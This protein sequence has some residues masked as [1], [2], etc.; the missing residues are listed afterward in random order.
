M[1]AEK[2]RA[3]KA[4]GLLTTDSVG[5]SHS[6]STAL[7]QDILRLV[8]PRPRHSQRAPLLHST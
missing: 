8:H 6:Y 5:S 4:G 2:G 7:A 3:M 1:E